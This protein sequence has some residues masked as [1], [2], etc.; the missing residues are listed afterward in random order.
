MERKEELKDYVRNYGK[1]STWLELAK[2][3]NI[4]PNTSDRDRS[5]YVRK[6]CSKII[7][8]KNDKI[9]S[10]VENS[11]IKKVSQWQAPN[12]EIRES[13]Q[14]VNDSA[15]LENF[16][17]DF[18]NDMKKFSPKVKKVSYKASNDPVAYEISLPDLHFGKDDLNVT[19]TEFLNTLEKLVTKAEGLNIERFILPIGNDGMNS[20]GLTYATTKGTPQW[21]SAEW[22]T[23]FRAYWKSLVCAID[24]LSQLAPVDVIV[25]QGN[26]DFER[27]FYLGDVIDAWYNKNPNVT[28]NNNVDTRKYYSYGKCMLMFTHGDKEKKDELPLIM[29]TEQPEMF[30]NSKHR[31]CH[32]GHLHKETLNEYRGIKVRHLPS[33]CPNDSWHKSRGYES[34]RCAQAFIWNK[35]KGLD[36]YLQVNI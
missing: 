22:Q 33:I 10:F 31:E 4:R 5:E 36:G 12:G 6:L 20:E 18:I 30:A 32:L 24:Y 13:V 25:V 23:T 17:E 21:D 1:T 26:H 8:K 34:Y 35:E 9:A 29:A 14:Y 28:V 16:R 7:K 27:M 15:N 11:K 2:M 3:F 19:I